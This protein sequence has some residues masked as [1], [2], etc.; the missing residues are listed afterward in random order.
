MKKINL[1]I[2]SIC[3][4]LLLTACS[5]KPITNND[6]LF[7]KIEVPQQ[8]V[9]IYKKEKGI[10]EVIAIEQNSYQFKFYLGDDLF[11][12]NKNEIV[13]NHEL[14]IGDE[15]KAVKKV[16]INETKRPDCLSVE[17]HLIP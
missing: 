13:S 9:C 8:A 15:F 12:I 4:L 2:Q 6:T 16:M 7:E 17:F 5:S 11:E 3:L 1:S 14:K 10:A